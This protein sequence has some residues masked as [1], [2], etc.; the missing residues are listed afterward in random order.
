MS[1]VRRA[2]LSKI[3][4]SQREAWRIGYQKMS[5]NIERSSSSMPTARPLTI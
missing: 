3:S 5:F 4:T 1:L 2:S